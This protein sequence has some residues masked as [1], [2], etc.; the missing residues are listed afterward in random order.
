MRVE[1][2]K[3]TMTIPIPIDK[4][5]GNGVVYTRE[6]VEQAV[7]H[8]RTNL[9]ILYKE[10]AETDAKVVGM[11]TGNS[12]V[13]IWDSENQVCKVSVDGVV[14]YGGADIIVNE[15]EEGKV[16]SFEITSLGLTT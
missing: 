1:N 10:S 4:P 11:T 9:P 6:A 16:S 3:I 5:D 13:V 8:L 14:F 12:H 2:T 7:N 15:I